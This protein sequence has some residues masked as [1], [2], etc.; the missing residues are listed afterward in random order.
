[1]CCAKIGKI[2]LECLRKDRNLTTK[3]MNHKK[4]NYVQAKWILSVYEKFCVT[5]FIDISINVY[6]QFRM[7]WKWSRWLA[8]VVVAAAAGFWSYAFNWPFFAFAS[9]INVISLSSTLSE[10]SQLLKSNCFRT[11]KLQNVFGVIVVTGNF[12]KLIVCVCVCSFFFSFA[13]I[14]SI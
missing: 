2:K 8:A 14:H 5:F 1:M 6:L 7:L 13:I 9:Q 12:G 11:F 10:R 3:W 4:K